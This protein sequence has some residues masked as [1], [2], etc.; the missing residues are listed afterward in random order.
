[1]ITVSILINSKPIYT[2]SAVSI[3]G[4]QYKVDDGSIIIH[5]PHNGGVELAKKLLE[6]IQ[7][8]K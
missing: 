6:T 3:G 4:N 7:E 1:M 5:E 8:V 2:R